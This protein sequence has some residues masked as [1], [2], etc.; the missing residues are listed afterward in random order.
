MIH[1]CVQEKKPKYD[2]RSSPAY[3]KEENRGHSQVCELRDKVVAQ[4]HMLGALKAF[5][6]S[7]V[8]SASILSG[9]TLYCARC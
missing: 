7:S 8:S 2:V 9:L 4:F 3:G 1:S 5:I 6:F